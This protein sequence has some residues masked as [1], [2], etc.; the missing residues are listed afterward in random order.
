[1]KKKIFALVGVIA[2]SSATLYSQIE[3][4]TFMLGGDAYFNYKFPSG[5]KASSDLNF[6]PKVGFFIVDNMAIGASM[7]FN[8]FKGGSSFSVAPFMRAYYKENF[9]GQLQVGFGRSSFE[10]AGTT[11]TTSGLNT[12]LD[13]GY[14]IFL[15]DNIALDPALY[16]NFYTNA[17]KYGGSNLGMKIGFQLFLNR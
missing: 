15:T 4:G 10:V 6:S 14:T 13:L 12:E 8:S 16:Y 3:Q 11:T 9:Y 2:L 1:M 7:S 5:V 17:S